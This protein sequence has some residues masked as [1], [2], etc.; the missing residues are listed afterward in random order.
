MRNRQHTNIIV[1]AKRSKKRIQREAIKSRRLICSVDSIACGHGSNSHKQTGWYQQ[2]KR[3]QQRLRNMSNGSLVIHENGYRGDHVRHWL[4]NQNCEHVFKASLKEVVIFGA[5]RICPFCNGSKDM[6]RY[7]SVEAIQ[8]HVYRLS[9]ETV[10]FLPDNVLSSSGEDYKFRC[11]FH[12]IFETT[13]DDFL[14]KNGDP[15]PICDFE[16][17]HF[18]S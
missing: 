13:F 2:R 16:R 17:A 12:T 5:T 11:V 10:E 15:C 7:G 3:A 8:E 14:E 4:Q 18:A 1:N 9:M 6:E